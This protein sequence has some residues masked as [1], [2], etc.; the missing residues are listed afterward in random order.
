MPH[1][2]KEGHVWFFVVFL[3]RPEVGRRSRRPGNGHVRG[4]GERAGPPETRG[5]ESPSD[6]LEK[7]ERIVQQL[8]IALISS[9]PRARKAVVNPPTRREPSKILC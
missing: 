1:K 9:S 4:P 6:G 3:G 5:E 8:V 2:Q 7:E